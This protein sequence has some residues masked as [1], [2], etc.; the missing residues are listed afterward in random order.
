MI[1]RSALTGVEFDWFAIDSSGFLALCS[2]A[3]FGPI[4]DSVLAVATP[5]TRPDDATDDLLNVLPERGQAVPEGRGPGTC[6]EWRA[7]ARRGF[8]VYDW[9]HR[10]G[11]YER[12]IHPSAPLRV[13]ACRN[14]GYR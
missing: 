11:P 1:Y 7:L 3:G 10:Q 9:R 5:T 14:P 12:V 6:E 2:S 13:S 8:F 4:P